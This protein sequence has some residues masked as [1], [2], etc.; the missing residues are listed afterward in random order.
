MKK[1][2]IAVVMLLTTANLFAQ[3]N[4]TIKTRSNELSFNIGLATPTGNFSKSDYANEGSGYAKSGL[5]L[6]LSGT[7]YFT[8]NWG[9][10]LLIGYSQFGYKGAMNLADGYKEDSGTDSTTL[11]TKG[12]NNSL[13]ILI[14]PYYKIPAGKHFTVNLNALMGYTNTHLAGFQVFYE[15]ALENSMTQKKSSGGGFAFQLGISGNYKISNRLFIKAGADYFYSKPTINIE[16][17]NYVVN[18]GRR[19]STYNEPVAGINASVGV[20][21][22]F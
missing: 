4:K 12:S 13:S 1:I 15:D 22:A 2:L 19:I 10:G 21:L 20:G 5:H 7:H 14:G 16:Y 18:S 6:N 8:K 3:K 17:E 9:I 11:Y